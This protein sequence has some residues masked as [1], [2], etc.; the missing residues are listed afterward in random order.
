MNIYF[1][2]LDDAAYEV[3]GDK[4]FLDGE[5]LYVY[6]C[7]DLRGMFLAAKVLDARLVRSRKEAT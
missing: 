5:Y 7:E 1:I 2:R 6:A 3:L 4:M